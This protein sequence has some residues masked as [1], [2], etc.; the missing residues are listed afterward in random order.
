MPYTSVKSARED[1]PALKDLSTKQAKK[2]IS[3]FNALV[4]EENMSESSAIPIAISQAKEIEKATTSDVT[5][6]DNGNLVYRGEKFPGY[7]RP[8]KDSGGKQGKV[9]AKKGNEIKVVRFGDPSMADNQ[10]VEQ[11]DAYYARHGEETD[12]F[13]AKYWSNSYLWP[14]GAQKGKGP[15]PFHTLNKASKQMTPIIKALDDEQKI[16]IEVVYEP[17]KLDAHGQWARPETIRKACENFNENLSKGNIKPNFYHSKDEDGVVK[18]TDAFEIIKSWVNEVDC[19]IGDQEVPEGTWICKVKYLDDDVW[20]LRKAG[21]LCGVSMGA[22]G[23]VKK[24]DNE[25]ES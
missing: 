1:I 9:L 18:S 25:G 22:L 12:K 10:S 17:Y 24:V 19:V 6:D 16:A 7:N 2:F 15:K 4:E 8:K 11:N 23:T 21:I 3:V 14:R 5:K 20:E 13:S